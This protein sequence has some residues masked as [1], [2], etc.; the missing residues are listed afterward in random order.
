MLTFL[1]LLTLILAA[2]GVLLVLLSHQ[3]GRPDISMSAREERVQDYT[4]MLRLLDNEDLRFLRRQPGATRRMERRLRHE[5]AAIF[6]LYLRS[7]EADFRD[8]SEALK[9]VMVQASI[10]RRDLASVVLQNQLR[11]AC[12]ASVLRFQVLLFRYGIGNVNVGGVLQPFSALHDMLHQFGPV[13]V[14]S[15]S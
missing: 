12:R 2:N 5:R 9:L 11:F 15:L 7:L 13:A 4:P 8:A 3:F 1:I 14:P 10:D 6:S